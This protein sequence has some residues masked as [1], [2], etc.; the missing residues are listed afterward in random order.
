MGELNAEMWW[1]CAKVTPWR[2]ACP[3]S[4]QS[5]PR[6]HSWLPSSWQASSTTQRICEFHNHDKR[7]M[8]REWLR[9]HHWRC[10]SAHSSSILMNT[11][12]VARSQLGQGLKE[13]TGAWRCSS[14]STNTL[15]VC[16][17][18]CGL[19]PWRMEQLGGGELSWQCGGQRG[20]E[21]L[22]DGSMHGVKAWHSDE[23]RWGSHGGRAWFGSATRAQFR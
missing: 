21:A 20:D 14:I 1:C 8:I 9:A 18:S 23:L 10:A 3:S 12:R 7:N 6:F 19:A 11:L 13:G 22:G 2:K 15:R 4:S 16:C 17:C 5:W